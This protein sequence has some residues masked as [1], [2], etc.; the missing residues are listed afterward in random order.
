[1]FAKFLMSFYKPQVRFSSNFASLWISYEAYNISARKFN[2]IMSHDT[3]G[4]CR[5]KGKLAHGLKNDIK[6]FV[7]FD[8]LVL[9]KAYIV[10][11]EKVYKSYVSW[12]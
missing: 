1:M 8:G 4:W 12:H 9:S 2:W 10:L 7:N 3:E 5:I 6:N 11:D